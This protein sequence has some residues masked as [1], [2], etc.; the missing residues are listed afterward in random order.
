MAMQDMDMPEV[1]I[2]W[3][4]SLNLV[5]KNGWASGITDNVQRLTG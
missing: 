3:F 1:M 4:M 2:E 5:I